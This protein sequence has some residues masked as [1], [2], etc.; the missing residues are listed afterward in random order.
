MLD[1]VPVGTPLKPNT[2]ATM[3]RDAC[4]RATGRSECS[5]A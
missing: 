2:A 3:F 5:A 4:T 1:A